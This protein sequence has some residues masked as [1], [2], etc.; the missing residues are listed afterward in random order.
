M[1]HYK[2]HFK[3]MKKHFFYFLFLLVV[4]NVYANKIV[5][6][7]RKISVDLI[8]SPELAFSVKYNNTVV[9]DK[10]SMGLQIDKNELYNEISLKCVSEKEVNE[11]YPTRGAHAMAKNHYREYCWE[12]LHRPTNYKY[13]LEMRLFD[14]G[15]GY[16]FIMPADGM[17]TVNKEVAQWRLPLNSRVWFGERN[18][19]WKLLTY[20]GEWMSTDATNLHKVS[21]QGPTQ[22]MPLLYQTV[23]GL[24]LMVAEAGLYNYSGMRLLVKSDGSLNGVFTEKDGFQLEGTITTPWRV[25]I[26]TNSLNTLVNTDIITNL[27]PEADP[28]LFKDRSWI[29]PGR[30]LWSWWSDLDGRYMTV[31][32]EQEVIDLAAKMGYEY[33]TL[34]EGWEK[35]PHKWSTLKSLSDYA[36]H[37]GVGLFVWRHW[38]K[39]NNSDDDYL[40]M[41]QFMD[42]LA[43]CGIKGVKID[44]MNG[45]GLKQIAFTQAVLT[46]AAKRKLLIN[47]HGC[48]KPSGESRTFPNELTREAVRG[49]ELN[50]I[51]YNYLKRMSDSGEDMSKRVY[52]PGNENYSISSRHNVILPFTRCVL[53]AA[54]YT[55]IA[56][57]KPG[58]VS[59]CQHLAMAYLINS[60]MVVLAENPFYL[61]REKPIQPA[62]D[63]IRELP[64]VWDETIVLP[65]SKLGEVAALARRSGN[66]WYVAIATVDGIK[67]KLSL[68]FLQKGKYHVTIL[69]DNKTQNGFVRKEMTL[70]NGSLIPLTLSKNGG[71]VIRIQ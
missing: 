44:F 6:P 28:T 25:L 51:T 66:V 41:R 24:Y 71:V 52:K 38:N 50:R 62:M 40:Q 13:T 47:F 68:Y 35:F 49:I 7:L 19:M 53:G 61:F 43:A 59:F 5:S 1:D 65:Q 55:P 69:E 54:D 37:K 27:S 70:G 67:E 32:G 15:M 11:P 14:D 26:A 39:L 20:A 3:R 10:S 22:T 4:S 63:F 46:N 2:N 36:T 12:V 34:D 60:P 64:A 17:R 48:Q 33:S 31:E 23:D 18:S 9:C 21:S 42:S 29:K 58:D 56:F 30:S 16:R 8:T 57:S 45:E